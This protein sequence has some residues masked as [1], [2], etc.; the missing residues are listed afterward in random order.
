MQR[1]RIAWLA[2]M[3]ELGLC[4]VAQARVTRN[5]I[6]EMPPRPEP[7]GAP[8][9]PIACEQIARRAFVDLD[10]ARPGHAMPAQASRV[11]R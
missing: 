1:L 9:R 7:A 8:A 5:E 4:G 2:A 3:V 6:D 10:P 11:L